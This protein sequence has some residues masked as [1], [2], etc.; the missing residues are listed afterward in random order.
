[1]REWN[2]FAAILF[3]LVVNA[4]C[5]LALARIQTSL[6]WKRLLLAIVVTGCLQY[7]A[8]FILS[9]FGWG[10]PAATERVLFFGRLGVGATV[11]AVTALFAVFLSNRWRLSIA[12][13]M[14]VLQ[15]IIFA[16]D[17]NR[18]ITLELVLSAAVMALGLFLWYRR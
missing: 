1:M 13:G 5:S 10:W 6:K 15:A 11:G 7:L 16:P 4:V 12:L 3:V 9:G 8:F 17:P 2:P 18:Y 14:I